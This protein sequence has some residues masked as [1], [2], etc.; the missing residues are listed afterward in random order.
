MLQNRKTTILGY[1]LLAGAVID[2]GMA[3]LGQGDLNNA[4]ADVVA[5]LG[6]LGLINASDGGH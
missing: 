4:H 1:L 2:F 3:L 6:G 5:A